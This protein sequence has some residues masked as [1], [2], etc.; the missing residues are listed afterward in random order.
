MEQNTDYLRPELIDVEARPDLR[1][2]SR[3]TPM[4]L[5][6]EIY[7]GW[8][9]RPKDCHCLNISRHGIAVICDLPHLSHGDQ[10]LL[11]LW[12]GQRMLTG[13]TGRVARI[14]V[15]ERFTKLG[16]AFDSP[17]IND[18]DLIALIEH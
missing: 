18:P 16:I 14:E 7:T 12:N 3:E 9:S 11:N 10:V 6:V 8:S 2:S 13:V 1:R 17:Y 15:A 4:D 5:H